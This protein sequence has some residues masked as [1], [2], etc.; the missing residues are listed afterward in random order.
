MK[1]EKQQLDVSSQ[2]KIHVQSAIKSLIELPWVKKISVTK[3]ETSPY[4]MEHKIRLRV[5]YLLRDDWTP[6]MFLAEEM[7]EKCE[8]M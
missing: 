4:L 8:E 6:E 3:I 7:R 5:W 2:D 1:L